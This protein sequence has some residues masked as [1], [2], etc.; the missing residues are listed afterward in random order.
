VHERVIAGLARAGGSSPHLEELRRAAELARDAVDAADFAALGQA[1]IANTD[2]QARLHP[3]LVG[4]Q[5][6]TAIDAARAEGAL[7]WKVNGA[8]GDGGSLTVLCGADP[9][10]KG[11][12]G[13]R[14]WDA[15]AGQ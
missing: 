6:R 3:D 10:V 7:G 11:R 2:A 12:T 9:R 5:A 8:G 1:M 13:L 4:A 14:V 15:A